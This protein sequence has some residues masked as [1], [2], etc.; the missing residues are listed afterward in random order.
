MSWL[1]EL[2]A[3][4]AVTTYQVGKLVLLGRSN[5]RLTTSERSFRRAMGVSTDGQTLWLATA[6]QVWRMEHQFDNNARASGYDRLF[7]PRIAYTTG[8]LDLHDIA[9]DTSGQPLF[10]ATLFNCLGT[11][12]TEQSFEQVWRPPFISGLAAEDRCHLNGLAMVDGEPRFVTLCYQSD[13]NRAWKS[14]RMH[15]GELW[16]TTADEPIVT[17]LSMPH[18]PR[19]HDGRLWLLNSGTGYLGSVDLERGEFQPVAFVPGYAR[20]L[21]FVDHYA[22]VGLSRPREQNKFGGLALDDE[23]AKRGMTSYTG[24]AIVDLVSGETVHT[25]EIQGRIA[26]LY[27]VAVLRGIKRPAALGLTPESL[28]YNVWADAD[29]SRRHWRRT[30]KKK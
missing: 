22:I 20:G 18:S 27:D 19:W 5:G 7:V 15:G 25:L 10:V 9:I 21:A 12:S 13:I 24:L 11:V 30:P 4:L 3:S 28:R 17:G 16:S 6:Y 2:D 14:H 1:E 26:E 8:D 29:G 23:L